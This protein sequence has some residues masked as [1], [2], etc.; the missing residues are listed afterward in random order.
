MRA[1]LPT[2]DTAGANATTGTECSLANVSSSQPDSDLGPPTFILMNSQGLFSAVPPRKVPFLR[3]MA[4]EKNAVLIAITESWLS[5][6]IFDQEPTSGAQR[7]RP[8][9]LQTNKQTNKLCQPKV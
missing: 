7:V 2:V 5:E 4:E 1:A 3:D 6:K 8:D 9:N